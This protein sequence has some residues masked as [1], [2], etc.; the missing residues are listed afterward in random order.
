[1]ITLYRASAD[2]G[3]RYYTIHNRQRHLFSKHSFA[4]SWGAHL[5]TGRERLYTFDSQSEM[6]D[7]LQQIVSQR[8]K[9]GYKVLYSYFGKSRVDAASK[10]RIFGNQSSGPDA[11]DGFDT[12]RH[13]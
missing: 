11:A 4:V 9:S 6:E 2:G 3:L 10:A 5:S 7:K 8:L 13:A 12:V 1:M